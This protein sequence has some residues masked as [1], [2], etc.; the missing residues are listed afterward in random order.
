VLL[1]ELLQRWLPAMRDDGLLVGLDPDGR[2][3]PEEV[4]P[5]ELR[6]RVLNGMDESRRTLAP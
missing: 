2:L 5:M 6:A 3:E 1:D 4:E